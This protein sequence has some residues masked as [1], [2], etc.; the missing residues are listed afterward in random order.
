MIKQIRIFV[1]IVEK[2]HLQNSCRVVVFTDHSMTGVLR[3]RTSH[4]LPP[5]TYVLGVNDLK[6]FLYIHITMNT[7][8]NIQVRTH[9]YWMTVKEY[10]K[11]SK[12]KPA[13]IKPNNDGTVTRTHIHFL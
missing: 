4:C 13:E 1:S 10:K 5:T 3:I 7:K 8:Q 2:A 11:W 6:I 12:S 9:T